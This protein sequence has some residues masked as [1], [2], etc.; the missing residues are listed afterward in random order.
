VAS[1]DLGDLSLANG[2]VQLKGMRWE[3]R[4]QATGSDSRSSKTT[5]TRVFSLGSASVLGIRLPVANPKQIESA[6]KTI[7]QLTGPLGLRVR[8]PA[9]VTVGQHG[10]EITPLTVVLGGRTIFGPLLGKV[11]AGATVAQIEN[12]LKPAIFDATSC[13]EL[14]GLLKPTGPL[15]TYYNLLGAGYPIVLAALVGA[16][17]GSGEVDVKIGEVSTSIDDTY[18]LT[19]VTGSPTN[20][21]PTASPGGSVGSAGVESRS[22][23]LPASSAAGATGPGLAG[24]GQPPAPS[25]SPL[26]RRKASVHCETTSAVGS[27]MCWA[28]HAPVGGAAAAL[29]T[30]G[31]LAADEFFTRRRSG[32]LR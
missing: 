32:S 22:G 15:N 29:I 17:D 20:A 2:L 8:M 25:L 19:P 6:A 28:G 5:S 16:L 27:P 14:G 24:L 30:L 12:A 10:F 26:R 23:A 3:L 4:Q 9:A 1:A 18:Y 13:N 11:F 21:G 31:L 7:N